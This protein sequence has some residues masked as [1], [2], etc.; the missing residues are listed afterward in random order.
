MK[1][2]MVVDTSV[3]ISGLIGESGPARAVL[4][5]GLE[6]Q[7]QP[8]ISSPLFQEYEAVSSRPSIREK[9]PFSAGELQDFLNAWYSCCQWVSIYY[10]WR[11]NLPDENDNFLYELA[12]AGNAQRILTQ[13]MRDMAS[14]LIFDG[15]VIQTPEQ[16]LR[17]GH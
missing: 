8:L 14:E 5:Q 6:N 13:N 9:C 2:R 11:P 15:I 3:L 12:V 16:F 10:L 17:G 1:Q 4:R 7:Y